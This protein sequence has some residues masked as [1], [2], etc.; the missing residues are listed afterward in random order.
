MTTAHPTH[1]RV[2]RSYEEL[3]REL[4]PKRAEERRSS[5]V[6]DDLLKRWL[7][8]FRRTIADAAAEKTT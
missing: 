8:A 3:E 2:F 7:E 6:G 5:R 1:N 4:M